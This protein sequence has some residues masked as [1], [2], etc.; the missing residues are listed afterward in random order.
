[1]IRNIQ[2]EDAKEIKEICETALGHK[3]ETDLIKQK[4]DELSIDSSYYIAVYVDETDN[5]VKGF[6]QA[7]K[8]NLLYGENGWNIIAL[9]VMPKEQNRGYG[10]QLLISLEHYA[11]ERGDSFVRL[12]S[13]IERTDAHGFYEHMGYVSSKIQKYFIKN[14][15]KRNEEK[16]I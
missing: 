10:R 9:A 8:Y 13:R 5:T 3:T 16:Q 7:E 15:D 14:L 2:K 11:Q 4:I 1:M 12:N 6:I